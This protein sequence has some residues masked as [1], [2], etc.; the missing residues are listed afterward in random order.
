MKNPFVFLFVF[1]FSIGTCAA[2]ALRLPAIISDHMVVQSGKAIPV[3]GWAEPG[4]R[5]EVRLGAHKAA[6]VA[7]AEG[8]WSVLLD[9]MTATH[10]PQTLSVAGA[11]SGTLTVSDVLV[12]DVW[13]GSGQSNMEFCL[14]DT[15]CAAEDLAQSDNPLIRVFRVPDKTATQPLDDVEPSTDG[16]QGRWLLASPQTLPEVSGVLYL[17]GK[18]IAATQRIPV[19]LIDCC[20]GGT[21]VEAWMRPEFLGKTPQG[22]A[23]AE[24]SFY[25]QANQ[26]TLMA[27]YL[28]SPAYKNW[29]KRAETAAAQGKPAPKKP[30][31]QFLRVGDRKTPY[32]L[33]NAMVHP[34][35]PYPVRGLLW[36]QAEKNARFGY[37]EYRAIFPWLIRDWRDLWNDAALP[38]YFVQLPNFDQPTKDRTQHNWPVTR[39]SQTFGLRE[40]H[41]GMAVT[42]D[43]GDP[44]D[45][46]PRDK[47]SVA[48]RL[49]LLAR[50]QTYGEDIPHLSPMFDSYQID[51]AAIRVRL[52]NTYGGLGF[53]PDKAV[54]GFEIAG[55]DGVYHPAQARIEGDWVVISSP[56]VPAPKNARYAW[57]N[58]PP[59]PLYN[60]VG[61][62]AAPFS[63]VKPFEL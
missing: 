5:V 58:A 48:H 57:R 41:T 29:E 47:R 17:F 3:R 54:D 36:Y 50:A 2:G 40:P 52:K 46:H 1:L 12:G 35:L 55:E 11:Q 38:F 30:A 16:S 19:G 43:V 51:G 23:S 10:A 14:K 20:W 44:H 4:E 60:K 22:R 56:Q 26:A 13:L 62:P 34:I 32:G 25:E 31:V 59:S 49:A 18:E 6:A 39:E 45:V 28:E 21:S 24:K 53:A 8:R 63:T 42:I 61:L 15:D 9:A 27:Q 7:D 37:R 33:Y